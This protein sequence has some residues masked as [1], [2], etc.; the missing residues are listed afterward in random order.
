M[1]QQSTH[2]LVPNDAIFRIVKY[3]ESYNLAYWT[4]DIIVYDEA[5][6][7][8]IV[9]TRS[10]LPSSFIQHGLYITGYAVNELIVSAESV[11]F[12]N[13]LDGPFNVWRNLPKEEI[14]ER[15]D[16]RMACI[17]G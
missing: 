8:G 6:N 1:T 12:R 2:H 5:R 3:T 11:T 9:I 15:K 4:L 16:S 17:C 10:I 7:E 13:S 14:E